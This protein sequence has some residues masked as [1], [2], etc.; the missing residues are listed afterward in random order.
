MGLMD[1]LQQYANPAAAPADTAGNDWEEIA[2]SAPPEAVQGGIADAF[3]SDQTPPFGQ[4]VGQLFGQSNP[5]QQA[6][7]LNQ[8]L[9]AIGPGLLSAWAEECWAAFSANAGARQVTPEVASQLTPE[10]VQELASHAE[11]HNPGIVDQIGGFYA[12]HPQLVKGLGGAALAIALGSM[13]KRGAV[14]REPPRLRRRG[15]CADR[16]DVAPDRVGHRLR[17][18]CFPEGAACHRCS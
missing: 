3:R 18:G 16:T 5:H 14:D 11:R 12:Q 7:V 8:L 4:M 2:G 1:I 6:G 10:Q 9:G 17:D 13:A 15:R